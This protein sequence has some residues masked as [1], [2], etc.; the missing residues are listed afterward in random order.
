[1]AKHRTYHV[2]HCKMIAKT[3]ADGQKGERIKSSCAAET[4]VK[5][6]VEHDIQSYF[7]KIYDIQIKYPQLPVV[8]IGGRGYFPVEFL[9]QEKSRVG[10]NSEQQLQHVLNYHDRFSGHD[11][12]DR[13][14]EVKDRAYSCER[15]DIG[16]FRS[17]NGLLHEFQISIDQR[18]IKSPAQRLAAPRPTFSN[19]E[20]ADTKDGSWNLARKSFTRPAILAM[21]VILDFT[22]NEGRREV[23][24]EEMTRALFSS[25]NGHG[26]SVCSETTI[27]G[28]PGWRDLIYKF[29]EF[30][31][32][33]QQDKVR[34]TCPNNESQHR[35]I[36][37]PHD[38]F[39]ILSRE[40]SARHENE[41]LDAAPLCLAV[42]SAP[43]AMSKIPG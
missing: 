21:P 40:K 42:L 18:P 19:G 43:M 8:S 28:A 13:V 31:G 17:L 29:Y 7:L 1:M 15:T 26:M 32:Y 30:E 2:S 11:R 10:G 6:Q 5:D 22:K 12:A 25:M 38:R 9:Y 37:T 34:L 41:S 16:G 23:S 24:V 33:Q 4:F 36:L 35:N 14:C 39:I 3:T 20:T 27:N